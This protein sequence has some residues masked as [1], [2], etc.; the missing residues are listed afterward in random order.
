MRLYL[1]LLASLIVL[2]PAPAQTK[3]TQVTP[4]QPTPEARA[5]VQQLLKEGKIMRAGD[6]KRGMKG[7][8]LSVFQ[9][10]K[11]EKFGIEVLGTLERVNG[12]G[13]LVM[14]RVTDGPVVTRQSGIIQGMSGSPVYI[15]GKLLGAIAIGFGFPKEPIGGITPIVQM[16][17]GALPDN[18][19]KVAPLKVAAKTGEAATKIAALPGT[20]KATN[21]A[22]FSGAGSSPQNA[23][24]RKVAALSPQTAS[25][26]APKNALASSLSPTVAA[27]TEQLF[28]APQPWIEGA[29]VPKTPIRIGN[30]NVARVAVSTDWRIPDWSGPDAFSTMAMRPCTRL[31]LLSG[32]SAQSLPRW[33]QMLSPYGL[34][35]MIGGGMMSKSAQAQVFGT[36]SQKSGV[37]ANLAPGAAIGVQLASGDVDAT[38]VGTVT[39]RLGNRVLAFGHPMFNLGAV[40]MPMTTAYVH[41]IFPA[42][43][44]SFKLA[45]PIKT[46]GELQQDTNFA[47]GGTVGRLAETVPMHVSLLDPAKKIN[48]NWNMKLIKD[49]LFTP[50]LATNIAVEALQSTLGLD[51]GKTVNVSLRMRLKNGP[52]I[53]RTNTVYAQG[54]VIQ[55]ALGEFLNTLSLTQQ[56][57]FEKGDIAGMDLKIE[58]VPGRKTAR[59]R[60]IFADRNRVKAGERV[61]ISVVLEP[62]G[63]PN[64]SITK[65]FVLNVPSDA[66]SGVMRVAVSPA[67]GYWQARSSVGGAPPRPGNLPELLSAYERVGASDV[68]ELQASTPNR[69]LLVD[70]KK[71]SDPPPLWGRLV[72][73]TASTSLGAFNETIDKKQA[74]DYVL[75]GFQSLSIPVESVRPSDRVTSEADDVNSEQSVTVDSP[76]DGNAL[77]PAPVMQENI[78]GD[79]GG[80][81]SVQA[82]AGGGNANAAEGADIGGAASMKAGNGANASGI[83]SGDATFDFGA[84]SSNANASID[85]GNANASSE[86]AKTNDS[87]DWADFTAP[88]RVQSVLGA[89]NLQIPSKGNEPPTLPDTT[90]KPTLAPVTAP[91]PAPEV[92][93]TP[94]PSPTPDPSASGIARPPGRWIQ[95]T[96]ADFSGG[97]FTSTVVRDDGAVVPGPRER[98]LYSSA[99]PV[100][101]SLAVAP[102][103]TLYVGTGYDARLLQIKNGVSRVLYQGP[104]VAITALAL[105]PDGNL[106]AGVSPGGRVYRFRPDGTRDTLLQT[107]ETFVHALKLTPQGLYI[108]TG[109]PRAAV[110]LVANPATVSANPIVKPLAVLAQTHLQS[111]D[112]VGTDVYAGTGDDAVLYRIDKSGATALYQATNPAN[113]GQGGLMP[114][115]GQTQVIVINSN[116]VP[117]QGGGLLSSN[118]GGMR[119]RGLTAGNE[120]TSVAAMPD[121]EVFFGTLTSGAVYRWSAARGVEE[122][123]KSKGNSIYSLLMR[124]GALYAGCDGGAVWRLE[125]QGS[126][127]SAARVLDASQPQ[128]LALANKGNA[129]YAATANNAAVYQIGADAS[130]TSAGQYDSDIFD[131]KGLVKWGTLRS[132]GQGVSLQTRS[133]NTVDPDATW[134]KFEPLQNGKIVSPPGRYLQYRAAFEAGGELARVE[135]L[136]RAP[137]GAPAVKWSS[138]L[139]GEYLSGKKTLTWTG[140][141]PNKDPLRYAVEIAPLNGPFASVVDVTPTDNKLEIDTTKYA[142]GLYRARVKA[143]DAARNPDDPKT[144]EALSLPFTIDNTAPVTSDLSIVKTDGASFAAGTWKLTANGTDAT[145]PLVG[146]E[147]RI[148]PEAAKTATKDEKVVTGKVDE[149]KVD[150]KKVDEP[151]LDEPKLDD[152]MR[153]DIAAAKKTRSLWQAIGAGDGLF[154]GQSESLVAQLDGAFAPAGLASGTEIEVRLRD[155]AGNFVLQSL[156]LP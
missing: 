104:E 70:R 156:K 77:E 62:T 103:N 111:L 83:G 40:S 73:Q 67:A 15:N 5:L 125:G 109:G 65:R 11:V 88:A 112:V 76:D 97:N 78:G 127:V 118:N 9:G 46:V 108:G 151:K 13:D 2:R 24:A 17:Q 148:K 64:N 25:A 86:N 105:A 117:S 66:P 60:Q 75:S 44:I 4:L 106:Y 131:A 53:E 79:D 69:F 136:Y 82:G 74:S 122:Y 89:L 92:T 61:T 41:D 22:E 85:L 72:P 90:V 36:P 107:R 110:Y 141:D 84:T 39:Y 54:L 32:V 3:P 137:N 80:D 48:R 45:S 144:D 120:I 59:I 146:A 31:I 34:T 100:A 16:I 56:N 47:I 51:A 63:E 129:V 102:D 101:W 30:R 139:G 42:Y 71:V 124:N 50:Q 116:G 27:K 94:S 147:W 91:T 33:S 81:T 29:Y 153:A 6:A 95:K 135:A 19:P 154:D 98:K 149:K 152:K 1:P 38:G 26:M 87:E 28:T 8:G 138:L 123:W 145:S 96:A 52:L 7:Y 143:S 155:A 130:G 133:G 93:P 150:E 37:Q 35:P 115:G 14:I 140:A 55:G 58:V 49:P 10:T 126:E 142:D 12:G 132:L 68:L 119:G 43:D 121:G 113:A 20:A 99:E 21:G 134:S 18:S 128:V 57:P 23:T 114:G